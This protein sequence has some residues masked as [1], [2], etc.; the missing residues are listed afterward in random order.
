MSTYRAITT[1]QGR[2]REMEK[3]RRDAKPMSPR[4]RDML[5]RARVFGQMYLPKAV[6][7][8]VGVMRN[9]N[10]KTTDRMKAATELMDRCGM[11]R[12]MDVGTDDV[13]QN[14]HQIF[15]KVLREIA[16]SPEGPVEA[17]DAPFELKPPTED[18]P[19]PNGNGN[20]A[21]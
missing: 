10:E 19:T 17:I 16:A 14:I 2:I 8:L 6:A 18:D 3:R 20:V 15:E 11:P 9:P 1:N 7:L 12:R 5:Y 4:T 21:H 13:P